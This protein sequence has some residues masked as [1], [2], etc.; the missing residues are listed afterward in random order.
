MRIATLQSYGTFNQK[1]F[2]QQPPQGIIPNVQQ[3]PKYKNFPIEF[4]QSNDSGDSGFKKVTAED[5]VANNGEY[6][7]GSKIE[8]RGELIAPQ[9]RITTGDFFIHNPNSRKDVLYVKSAIFSNNASIGVKLKTDDFLQAGEDF[10]TSIPPEIGGN[11]NFGNNA[12]LTNGIYVNGDFKAGNKLN[13]TFISSKGGI[14]ELNTIKYLN[15]IE[16]LEPAIDS[17]VDMRKLIF[18]YP[19]TLEKFDSLRIFLYNPDIVIVTPK[20]D[21]SILKKIQFRYLPSQALMGQ[22]I[23]DNCI[24]VIPKV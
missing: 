24:K 22:T 10:Y 12:T 13:T 23:I 3:I 6:N 15:S 18:N 5:L 14:I 21:P 19:E 20:G 8:L 4:G 11:A 17:G 2:S 7:L 9:S 16:M 1:I